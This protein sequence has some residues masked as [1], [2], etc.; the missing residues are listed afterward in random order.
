[1]AARWQVV[2]SFLGS[3]RA[4]QLTISSGWAVAAITELHFQVYKTYQEK[5]EKERKRSST[6]QSISRAL[7]SSLALRVP[8]QTM[9]LEA[10]W[11]KPA[12]RLQMRSRSVW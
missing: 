11:L 2:Y 6:S 8:S 9:G 4:H 5:G 12:W 10:A 1:M 7:E 3:L